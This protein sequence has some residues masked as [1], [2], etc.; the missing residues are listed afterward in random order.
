MSVVGS[1]FYQSSKLWLQFYYRVQEDA[2]S[3]STFWMGERMGGIYMVCNINSHDRHRMAYTFG[4]AGVNDSY[5]T[6]YLYR[7]PNSNSKIVL[8]NTI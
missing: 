2:G 4:W 7:Y 3:R 5:Q 6:H 8:A 1:C